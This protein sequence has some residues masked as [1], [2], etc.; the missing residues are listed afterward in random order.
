MYHL[1]A[2]RGARPARNWS[3]SVVHLCIEKVFS[4]HK[5]NEEGR[6][7]HLSRRF[8]RQKFASVL[9][10]FRINGDL[11]DIADDDSAFTSEALQ[12]KL[13]V[14]GYQHQESAAWQMCTR[15]PAQYQSE[16]VIWSALPVM[17][18]SSFLIRVYLSLMRN[19]PFLIWSE[20]PPNRSGP[21]LIWV[22]LSLMRNSQF[23][24]WSERPRMFLIWVGL[25]LIRNR[26]LLIRSPLSL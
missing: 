15:V 18:N 19:G 3:Q 23:L 20:P 25:P 7:I 5:T 11:D 14:C 6:K 12:L 9:L 17:R 10:S 26:Q 22:S 16:F 1:R 21:F 8:F 13:F 2:I 24:I 4:K